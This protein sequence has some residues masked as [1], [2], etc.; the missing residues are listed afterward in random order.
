MTAESYISQPLSDELEKRIRER[1]AVLRAQPTSV[2]PSMAGVV[3]LE[4]VLNEAEAMKL[5]TQER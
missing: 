1:I 4:W 3:A 2:R 5:E